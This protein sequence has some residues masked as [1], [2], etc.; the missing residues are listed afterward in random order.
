MKQSKKVSVEKTQRDRHQGKD[1]KTYTFDPSK[2]A[3]SACAE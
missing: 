1:L 2:E 3:G